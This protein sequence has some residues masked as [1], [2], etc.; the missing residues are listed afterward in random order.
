M[1]VAPYAIPVPTLSARAMMIS[2]EIRTKHRQKSARRDAPER[3]DGLLRSHGNLEPSER[4][5]E[6]ERGGEHE[7]DTARRALARERPHAVVE[8]GRDGRERVRERADEQA[9]ER[10]EEGEE[11]DLLRDVGRRRPCRC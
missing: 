9:G 11:A 10:V 2:S 7:D 5:G 4:G 3:P 1:N 8:A 6:D